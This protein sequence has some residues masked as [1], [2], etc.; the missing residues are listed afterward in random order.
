MF[1]SAGGDNELATPFSLRQVDAAMELYNEY[2]PRWRR[3]DGSLIAIKNRAFNDTDPEHVL[4]KA[5]AINGLY[6]TRV[7][8]IHEAVERI[9]EVM[10]LEMDGFT[11]VERIAEVKVRGK[12]KRYISFAS[13][14]VHWFV[15]DKCPIFDSFAHRA[16]RMH[17][18]R[19]TGDSRIRYFEFARDFETLADRIG[20]GRRVQDMDRYLWLAGQLHGGSGHTNSEVR[21]LKER[22][23][24]DPRVRKL[25][26]EVRGYRSPRS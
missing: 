5:N 11:R 20:A 1:T 2:M 23:S 24:T 4:L 22:E 3:V 21:E 14:Y 18:P 6:S 16:L 10:Q 12:V 15:D 26:E 17:L 9:I 25:L 19:S 7:Y 8:A 13:K